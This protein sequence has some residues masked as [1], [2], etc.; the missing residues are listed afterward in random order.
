MDSLKETMVRRAT[1]NKAKAHNR[2]SILTI[3]QHCPP[4]EDHRTIERREMPKTADSINKER[5]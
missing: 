3:C 2:D 4:A 1:V 5:K